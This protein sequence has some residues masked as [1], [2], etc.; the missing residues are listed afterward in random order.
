VASD[1][2]VKWCVPVEDTDQSL[3][4]DSTNVAHHR[5]APWSHG[6]VKWRK[7]G[8]RLLLLRSDSVSALDLRSGAR[9]SHR[10]W[11]PPEHPLPHYDSVE[12]EFVVGKVRCQESA[13]PSLVVT[14]CGGLLLVFSPRGSLLALDSSTGEAVESLVFRPPDVTLNKGRPE[15]RAR[16]E[17][18]RVSVR[19][20]AMVFL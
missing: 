4:L 17:G 12:L 5:H 18:M 9:L 16:R 2:S 6:V 13:G 11:A 14:A 7:I 19:L 3:R 15:F 1:G 10:Q 8:E 20:H